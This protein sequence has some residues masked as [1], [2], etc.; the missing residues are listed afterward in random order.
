MKIRKIISALAL[1]IFA[2]LPAMTRDAQ[3]YSDSAN[4]Y[5]GVAGADF[6]GTTETYDLGYYDSADFVYDVVEGDIK[7]YMDEQG[8]VITKPL[9]KLSK[10]E[11]FLAWKA[12][13][14]YDIKDGEVYSVFMQCDNSS[15]YLS[16]VA[17][18]CDNARSFRDYG[19]FYF[20]EK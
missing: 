9:T 20:K 17:E 13:N 14:E 18:I 6:L 7:K 12:L 16:F 1:A 8:C 11:L 10:E 3:H 4:G 2:A 5:G 15:E 19:G